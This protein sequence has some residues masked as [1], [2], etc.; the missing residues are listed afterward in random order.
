VTSTSHTMQGVV[1]GANVGEVFVFFSGDSTNKTLVFSLNSQLFTT[2]LKS[3]YSPTP[4]TPTSLTSTQP[5]ALTLHSEASF[6]L[7]IKDQSNA[8]IFPDSVDAVLIN[9]NS[10]KTHV[11]TKL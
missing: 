8:A 7:T 3:F 11:P 10:A 1:K 5:S 6:D 9:T 2:T 4:S